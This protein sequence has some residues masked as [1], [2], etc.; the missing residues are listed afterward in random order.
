MNAIKNVI[1][2]KKTNFLPVITLKSVF[3]TEKNLF[4]HKKDEKAGKVR[5]F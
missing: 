4:L 1:T 5:L 3:I 2:G